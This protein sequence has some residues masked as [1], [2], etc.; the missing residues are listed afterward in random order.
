MNLNKAFVLGNITRDP[1]VRAL[2]SGQQVANFG[3]A[4]NRFYTDSSGQKKQDVEFHNIVAFGK[5]ADIGSRYLRKGSLVLVEGR[6][7]TRSW[8]DAQ[9][10]KHYKT[11][12][13]CENIQMGPK[14]MGGGGGQNSFAA[15][16][17]EP[18]Q[19]KN[20]EIPIIDENY[21]PGALNEN[22]DNSSQPEPE[23]KQVSFEGDTSEEIDIKDIPF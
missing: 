3:L 2:P 15:N 10:M 16:S 8:Q 13:I 7:K 11:E 12:I 19:Q 9:G 4:T 5:M 6:I 14:T 18:S 17:P 22:P 1:E 23:V 20:E 21:T